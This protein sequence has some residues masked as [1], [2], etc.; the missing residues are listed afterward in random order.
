MDGSV[1]R[2]ARRNKDWTQ[3][4]AAHAL[5]VTQAYL[6]MLEKGRR[7]VPETLV[8]KAVRVLHLAPTVLPLH[9]DTSGKAVAMRK[10][11]YAADLGS[12]G[13]PGFAYMKPRVRTNP[14]RILFD[15]LNEPDLDSRVAE[16]LPWLLFTYVDM[17]WHWLVRNAKL[18]D[19]Q[20]RL[21]FALSLAAEV[22]DLKGE[23]HRAQTL[24][25]CLQSLERARLVKED[26]FCHESMTKVERDWVRQH[27][28]STAEHWNLLTDLKGEQLGYASN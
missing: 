10:H 1:L 17:N 12:L 6:S 14:A 19:R 23:R 26:T 3:E 2:R 4:K 25:E 7:P 24:G 5:G 16:G 27:R 20:N 9:A 15:A 22:A 28:S 18:W 8:R 13:Y 21:G 11:D